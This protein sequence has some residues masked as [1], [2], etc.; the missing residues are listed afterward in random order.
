LIISAFHGFTKILSLLIEA[1]ADPRL[2]TKRNE[3][4]MDVARTTEIKETLRLYEIN[5][6]KEQ[7]DQK[8][9]KELKVIEVTRH[10]EE[11]EDFHLE[12]AE[13]LPSIN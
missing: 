11:D 10:T 3:K 5:W 1:K 4:A 12:S 2:K 8:I 13:H 7:F 6:E 9:E